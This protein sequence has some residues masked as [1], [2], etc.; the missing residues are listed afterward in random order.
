MDPEISC[1]DAKGKAS[2]FGALTGGSVFDTTTRHLLRLHAK[3]PPPEC[4]MLQKAFTKWE[5]ALGANARIWVA[6]EAAQ[7]TAVI[8]AFLQRIE[9]MDDVCLLYTSPSPRD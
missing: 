6:A 5:W 1:M 8:V 3:P 2:G 4:L 9:R 7:T